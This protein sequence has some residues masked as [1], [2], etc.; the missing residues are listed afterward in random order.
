MGQVRLLRVV[1]NLAG[2]DRRGGH[3][4]QL[5][6]VG[7]RLIENDP[8]RLRIQLFQ[9]F[10]PGGL[11]IAEGTGSLHRR[12][13]LAALGVRLG[14]QDPGEGVKNVVG[15]DFPA[16][17]KS[18]VAAQVKRVLESI[19]G[20]LPCLRHGRHHLQ[21]GGVEVEEPVVDLEVHL[22]GEAVARLGRVDVGRIFPHPGSKDLFASRLRGLTGG[23]GGEF[24]ESEQADGTGEG[25]RGER[26]TPSGA[27][28]FQA[29]L[30]PGGRAARPR[31]SRAAIGIGRQA[32]RGGRLRAD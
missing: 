26:G 21:T 16:I 11:P 30:L 15:G 19:T 27:M 25:R 22:I 24:E 12:Q 20:D 8:D 18:N 31:F 7:E 32:R 13:D 10:H 1:V 29:S 2:N 4:Q 14:I 6:E 5:Q 23:A 28:G 17:V 9:T 3:G